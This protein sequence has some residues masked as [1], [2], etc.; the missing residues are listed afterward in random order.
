[1]AVLAAR[2]AVAHVRVGESEV[3]AVTLAHPGERTV[4]EAEQAHHPV[5]HGAHGDERADGEMARAEVG[6]GGPSLEAIRQ[7]R[8]DVAGFE[9]HL[10]DGLVGGG[11]TDQIIE[12]A[13]ELLPLPT[14]AL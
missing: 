11:L 6:S 10:G 14:V 1:M 2:I 3:V 5:G 8:H 12:Q 9:D 7:E 13:L 4:V